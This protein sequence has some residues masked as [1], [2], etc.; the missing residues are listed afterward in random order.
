M[1]IQINQY[2]V[3]GSVA[4]V[5]LNAK[6]VAAVNLDARNDVASTPHEAIHNTRR[7]SYIA[8]GAYGFLVMKL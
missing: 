2:L 6:K 1:S 5:N 3:K 8:R 4:A 7:D